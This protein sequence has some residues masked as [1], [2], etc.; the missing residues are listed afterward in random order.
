MHGAQRNAGPG[1]ADGAERN[2]A[3]LDLVA[4]DQAGNHAADADAHGQRGVQIAGLGLADVKNVRPV[5]DDGGK[6]QRAEKPEIGV[7]ENREE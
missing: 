2:E 1:H 3:V 5:N 7:A 4:A 6:Q